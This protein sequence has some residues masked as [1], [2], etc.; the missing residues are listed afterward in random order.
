MYGV[1]NELRS[2]KQQLDCEFKWKDIAENMHRKILE[3]KS[4]LT[5]E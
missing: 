5:A 2:A 1:R 4:E 3:E